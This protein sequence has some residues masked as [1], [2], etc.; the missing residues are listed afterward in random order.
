MRFRNQRNGKNLR[1]YLLIPL[2]GP[3]SNLSLEEIDWVIVGGESGMKARPLNK[4]WVL[5]IPS[6]FCLKNWTDYITEIHFLLVNIR[7]DFLIPHIRDIISFS[8]EFKFLIMISE[9][10]F[11]HLFGV[12]KYSIFR[13][14]VFLSSRV[15][16]Q[17][18]VVGIAGFSV[19][20]LIN[21]YLW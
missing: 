21:P 13:P 12:P 10:C 9:L 14:S 20:I 6:Y 3:I 4:N 1:L 8:C 5:D 17:H 19:R 16:I 18:T 15:N 2:L 11:L 7:F